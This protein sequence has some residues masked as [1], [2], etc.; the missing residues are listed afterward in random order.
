MFLQTLLMVFELDSETGVPPLRGHWPEGLEQLTLS[1]PLMGITYE[2]DSVEFISPTV[3]TVMP[4]NNHEYNMRDACSMLPI[5]LEKVT[6]NIPGPSKDEKV[7][8]PGIFEGLHRLIRSGSLT[9]LHW[10]FTEAIPGT[11]DEY[12]YLIRSITAWLQEIIKILDEENKGRKKHKLKSVRVIFPR[13]GMIWTWFLT[14]W[15]HVIFD[16]LWE[17]FEELR[18]LFNEHDVKFTT[19][20]HTISD[21]SRS[22]SSRG[23]AIS[24]GT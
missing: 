1:L 3:A 11:D 9:E 17:A 6:I 16:R 24:T 8:G 20:L 12:E 23:T 14:I 21:L 13:E 19:D 4:A 22:V 15:K 7:S 10:A 18:I 2:F 5:N